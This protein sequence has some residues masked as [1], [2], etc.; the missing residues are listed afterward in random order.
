MDEFGA[1]YLPAVYRFALSRLNGDREL[2]SEVVQT[3]FVKA[4]DAL[5]G[6]HHRSSLF[7]WLCACCYNE[8]R[9]HRRSLGRM[10]RRVELEEAVGDAWLPSAGEEAPEAELRLMRADAAEGVHLALDL[11][12]DQYSQALEWKYFDEL[13]VNDIARRLDVSPKAAE[14]LLTRARRAFDRTW[15]EITAADRDASDGGNR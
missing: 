5:E 11:L 10:P 12:P 2:A 8:I 1:T 3:T 4:L 6:F 9:M 7:T 15:S 14:S 13:P